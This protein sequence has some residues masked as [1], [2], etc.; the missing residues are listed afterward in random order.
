MASKVTD[1]QHERRK[2][3][4]KTGWTLEEIRQRAAQRAAI[5]RTLERHE[6]DGLASGKDM[7]SIAD[8]PDDDD[9]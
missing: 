6:P 3:R 9:E 5:N 8:E 2:R 7:N 1:L 4:D